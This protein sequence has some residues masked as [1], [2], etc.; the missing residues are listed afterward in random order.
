[1]KRALIIQVLDFM[2]S[3]NERS[4]WDDLYSMGQVEKKIKNAGQLL[5]IELWIPGT[6]F[7]HNSSL[8]HNN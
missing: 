6:K 8:S 3:L 5:R 4:M 2:M 7:V 1:M